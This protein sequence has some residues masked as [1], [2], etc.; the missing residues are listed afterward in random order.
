MN[1]I[2]VIGAGRSASS[3]IKILLQQA[4]EQAWKITVADA[5]LDIA[6]RKVKGHSSGVAIALDANNEQ[7]RRTLISEH[8]L[9]ISMLPAFMHVEVV[10]DCI[11]LKTNVIT[12]SYVSDEMKS[13]HEQAK[14][15][16]IW[17]LNEMGL[18]PGIDHMSAMKVLD[19]I[20][21]IGGE[22]IG[23][24][25]FTGGL[26]APESDNNPWNYKFTWNPRN[27]VL[28]G[29]GGAVKFIQEGK[30]KYIPYHKLFRRTEIIRVPE[31]GKFEGY[32]NRDSLKYRSIYGLNDIPTIYRGT[33]RRPGFCKAWDL[34]I[35]LGMTDDAYQ[36]EGVENMTHREFMNSFLAYNATDSVELKFKYY[37]GIHQ[38]DEDLFDKVAW[39]GM[40]SDDLIGLDA[41][42]PAQILQHILEKKWTLAPDDRDM[43]VMWHK[44]VYR[45]AG[46]EKQIN[47]SM[48]MLGENNE[49]TAMSL[50][51]GLPLAIVAKLILKGKIKR[52]G[53]E[54]PIHPEVYGPVLEE[55]AQYGCQF[56]EQELTP[57][58]H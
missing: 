7:Q 19:H 54:L 55:L 52:T 43:I 58:P 35:Q 53:V 46:E 27:V 56:N 34:F 40:F 20:R 57:D 15:A 49:D 21:H 6:E 30:Y 11:A 9:V 23:F 18:D 14:A 26:V 22:I 3:L 37:L 39:L 31:Y 12:P 45:L 24:E 51:V 42:S 17:V 4:G 36:M 10:K 44:F 1:R 8:D 25:S 2:L 16:G 50:T 5:N 41:G 29:Q 28:A 33:L 13:L 38:D 48:V 32:A 47:S